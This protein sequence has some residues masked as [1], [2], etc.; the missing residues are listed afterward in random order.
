MA[1]VSAAP[2]SGVLQDGTKTL[3]IKYTKAD[4]AASQTDSSIIAAVSG[5]KLRVISMVAVC[6][7]NATDL[8]FNTKP[9]GSGTAITGVFQ[10]AANGGEVLPFNQSGWFETNA[11]EGLTATTGAGSTTGITMTYVEVPSGSANP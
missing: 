2:L 4:V 7:A 6:G 9:S 1:Q 3:R 11:G 8:T 10:N 5:K